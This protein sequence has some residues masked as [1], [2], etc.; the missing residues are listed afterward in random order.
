MH[1]KEIVTRH[2][3]ATIEV[4][5]KDAVVGR[6]MEHQHGDV[7]DNVNDSYIHDGSWVYGVY[8]SSSRW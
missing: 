3:A 8:L 2:L 6:V 1:E 4:P 7:R 5:D